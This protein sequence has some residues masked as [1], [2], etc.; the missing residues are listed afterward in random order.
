LLR[1]F[2][3]S[4]RVKMRVAEHYPQYPHAL[5]KRAGCGFIEFAGVWQ[6]VAK[7]QKRKSAAA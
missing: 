3:G 5:I 1:V 7:A 6:V 4:L 2:A